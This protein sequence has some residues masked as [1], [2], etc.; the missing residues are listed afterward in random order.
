M[1]K[2]SDGDRR[3]T[4]RGWQ[5]AGALAWIWSYSAVT[6]PIPGFKSASQ[7]EQNAGTM[8]FGQL[9]EEAM[10]AIDVALGREPRTA[11]QA[12]EAHRSCP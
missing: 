2:E 8:R 1:D 10:A 12:T 6:I 9:S 3:G 5:D 7:V 11:S 4:N